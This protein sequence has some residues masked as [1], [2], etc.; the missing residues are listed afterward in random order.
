MFKEI[1]DK[2][3][4]KKGIAPTVVCKTIGLSNAAYSCWDANSVPR[5]TT[6]IK[7]AEYFNV[8]VDYL[9]GKESSPT[10]ILSDEER[11][12]IVAYRSQSEEGKK[13]IR[14][15]LGIE[16]PTNQKIFSDPKPELQTNL[17]KAFIKTT[18]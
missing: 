6:L 4:A 13:I 18:I 17:T 15:S 14:R 16:E 3:C 8:S 7:I 5:K 11:N 10:I 9:L 2:L 1:F 12:I